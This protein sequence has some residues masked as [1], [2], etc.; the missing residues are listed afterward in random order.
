V[1]VT[2]LTH[3]YAP[4][5]GAP[6]TRLRA[7]AG[8]IRDLGHEVRVITGHPHYPTGRVPAGYRALSFR[9]DMIDGIPVQRLP[10][11]AR[12][13][14]G[15]LDRVLD[16]GSFA[17]SAV[18]AVGLIAKAD[19]VVVESP[20]LFLGLT[21]RFHRAFAHRP[22]IFHVADPWPDFPIEMGVLR[23]RWPIAMARWIETRAYSGAALITTVTPALVA[24]LER[25]PAARSKVRLLENGVDIDRFDPKRDPAGA[26]R[27]LGWEEATL[28]LAYVGT[29]GLAQGVETL[30]DAVA[31]LEELGV[32]LHIVGDGADRQQL[33]TDAKEKGLRN[34]HFHSAVSAEHVPAVLAA[35]DAVVVMLRRG[36]L[37]EESLPTKLIE[38]LAAG[39]PIIV[40]A[41]GWPAAIVSEGGAGF[42]S[43]PEDAV[44]LRQ[45]ILRCLRVTDRRAIGRNGR[46]LAVARFDRRA[47]VKK[48]DEYLSYAETPRS[49]SG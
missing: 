20:P 26:R 16:Q 1:R 21:A 30:V 36:P 28:T 10:V 11:L 12:A 5:V 17:L 18:A 22:Y 48:L 33:V 13:N 23:G 39:R 49:T 24:R 7:T 6:Q 46:G 41:S 4:E 45:S 32:V 31:G 15:F 14:R 27:E 43:P 34:V 19:V 2:L 25:N 29:V 35:A 9:R 8:L 44:A 42:T 40:S 3:Y 47:I 37:Y 38:G